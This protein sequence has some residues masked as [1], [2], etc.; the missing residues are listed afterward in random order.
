ME[1]DVA[2]SLIARAVDDGH[3]AHGY[4]VS[5]DLHGSCDRLASKLLARLFPDAAEQAAAM[6]HADIF[7]LN[8]EGKSRTI[9]VASM[10]ERIVEPVSVSSYS[11]G[12]KVGVIIGADRMETEAA[13]AF[14]KTLEEPPPKTLFLLLTD[15]PEAV[16][17]T[18]V[19]RTQRIDLPCSGGLLDGDAYAAV[20]EVFSSR[21]V[22][23]VYRKACA[24]HRL[25][26]ILEE[27]ESS[28]DDTE[29]AVA[30]QAFYRTV[31][32]F[33]RDW[34]V[35]G[36]LPRH[37]AFAN[38]SAVEDAFRQSSRF[39]NRDAVLGFLVDR[40]TWPAATA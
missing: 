23:G 13:N 36:A 18:I 21:G 11:G 5:G 15:C 30:R 8:A 38:V 28:V 39:I 20:A 14:L 9:H 19:S 29:T 25:S 27:V 16:L 12:W 35:E 10:R 22:D 24:G 7:V 1:V 32:K 26:E 3:A 33:V 31:M 4:L 37:Q 17:P 40:L 6:Q 34:M 2:Y